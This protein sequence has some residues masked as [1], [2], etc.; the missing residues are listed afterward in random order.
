MT[1]AALRKAYKEKRSGLSVRDA[2]KFTD[3]IL[4]N[5]QQI[6]LPFISYV[7]TYIAS[8]KLGEADTSALTR[9]LEFKNPGLKILVPKIDITSGGMQHFH[10]NDDVELVHNAFGIAEPAGGE[11]ISPD[12]IDLVLIPLLAF[13]KRG[14]R[15]GYGKGYY[16]RFLSECRQD[17]IKIGLSFF[18][19]E[20]RIDDINQFD[21]PLNYCVTPQA[22]FEFH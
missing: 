12:E 21:I 18:E 19:P 22:V 7:H 5:F 6:R 15:V 2:G 10:F 8:E 16:D 3:L 11:A 20:E 1:K 4:I 9:Y 14:Y 17:V 13:D